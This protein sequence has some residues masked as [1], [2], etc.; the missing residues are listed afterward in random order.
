METTHRTLTYTRLTAN[1]SEHAG[2]I[3]ARLARSLP[4]RRVAHTTSAIVLTCN[5]PIPRSGGVEGGPSK[6]CRDR[7]YTVSRRVDDCSLGCLG[8]AVPERRP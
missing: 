1:D 3:E 7:N 8:Y 6:N 5:A 2:G 4:A